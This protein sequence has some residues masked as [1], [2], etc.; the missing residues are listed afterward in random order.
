IPVLVC[1]VLL[2]RWNE[3]ALY[4]EGVFVPELRIEVIE[5]LLRTPDAFEIQSH[6]LSR[7]EKQALEALR[8]V[9]F[10][11]G[12]KSQ[13]A[14]EFI[15]IVKTLVLS[16]HKLSAYARHTR[17]V[18]PFEGIAVRDALLNATD[19]KKLLFDELPKAL[20]ITLQGPKEAAEFAA[21]LQECLRGL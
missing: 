12:Y 21:R 16:A 17:H 6:L 19:P 9:S 4:E 18:R 13:P 11:D 1:A 20:S 5:R 3:V 15:P 8:N 10:V 7:H 14:V 2:S